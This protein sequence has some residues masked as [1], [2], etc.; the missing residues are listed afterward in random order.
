MNF[1][2]FFLQKDNRSKLPEK[3][4]LDSHFMYVRHKPGHDWKIEDG[5]PDFSKIKIGTEK[6]DRQSMNWNIFS[7]PIWARFNDK[8]EYLM[9]LVG[10]IFSHNEFK[11]KDGSEGV[12]STN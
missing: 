1:P 12:S 9:P 8:T 11:F 4:I 7:I 10:E 6:K 2:N 3:L 5:L